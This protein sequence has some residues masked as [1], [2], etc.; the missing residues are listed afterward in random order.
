[1]RYWTIAALLLAACQQQPKP[2]A[3][4][5]IT[6]DGAHVTDAAALIAHGADPCARLHRLPRSP[7]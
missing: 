3:K 2:A 1:M 6:F 4:A 7:S 5:E